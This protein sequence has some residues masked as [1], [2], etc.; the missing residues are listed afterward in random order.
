M[1]LLLGG[2]TE[3]QAR[4]LFSAVA[5]LAQPAGTLADWN[6]LEQACADQ[7]PDVVAIH[8]GA[9]PKQVLQVITRVRAFSPNLQFL[10]ITDHASGQLVQQVSD[11]G[12]A[13]LVVLRECPE[14]LRRALRT[15]GRRE[16]PPVADGQAIAVLG[17]KGGVGTTSVAVNLADA[18]AQGKQDR[19]IL[20]D[21]NVYIED[22]STVALD[23]RPRPGALWFVH[24]A[25]VVDARTWTEAPPLHSGGFRVLADG[26]LAGVEPITAEQVVF[27][28]ERLKER[29]EHVVLD[30][31]ADVNEVSLAA[32]TAADQRLIVF[33][34]DLSA[35]TRL[36]ASWSQAAGARAPGRPGRP[37]PRPG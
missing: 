20:V 34:R 8:L 21:L 9:R 32:C 35:R 27:F 30:L 2:L 16:R 18:L 19:V 26:D 10:A 29:Y 11:A 5:D 33:T 23:L 13:D 4:T 25:R 31:G 15:L 6:L 7:K 17:A 28:I 37:Q 1:R 12:C 22:I 36:G 24:R 14:D 3:Q